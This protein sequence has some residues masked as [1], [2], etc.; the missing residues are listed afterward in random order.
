MSGSATPMIDVS[1]ITRNCATAMIQSAFQRRGSGVG[2]VIGTPLVGSGTGSAAQRGAERCA[3][4]RDLGHGGADVGA[5]ERLELVGQV[6]HVEAVAG[7][8]VQ[9]GRGALA[10]E[11]LQLLAKEG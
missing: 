2:D 8:P 5:A 11:Q 4:R 1:M 10:L 9:R 3:Q 6:G 7:E